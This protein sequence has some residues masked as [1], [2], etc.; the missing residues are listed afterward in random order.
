MGGCG[1]ARGWVGG[2]VG[3]G[4]LDGE[5]PVGKWERVGGWGCGQWVG[6]EWPVGGG[7]AGGWGSGQW[8]GGGVASGWAWRVGRI[9]HTCMFPL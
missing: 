2:W 1:G 8:V 3:E 7:V 4:Q 5:R 6:V 9:K